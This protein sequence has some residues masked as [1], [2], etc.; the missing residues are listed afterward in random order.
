MYTSR[1][2]GQTTRRR[3]KSSEKL[4]SG[5]KINCAADNAAGLSI[6][7]RMRKQI[8]GL[9]QASENIEDGISLCQVADGALD[10]T[11][12]ILQRMRELTVQAA[13]GTNSE[14]DRQA[15]EREIMQLKDEV[16]RIATT[17][18]F[19]DAIY[20]LNEPATSI[21]SPDPSTP[22]TP[23]GSGGVGSNLIHE[24]STIVTTPAPCTYEGKNYDA[25]DKIIVEGLTTNDT[26]VWFTGGGAYVG[27]NKDP[28]SKIYNDFG[29]LKIADLKTD[30]DGYL[31]YDKSGTAIYAV[32]V[33]DYQ[34]SSGNP[35]PMHF[36][37]YGETC[38]RIAN[39]EKLR[40]MTVDDLGTQQQPTPPP[41][42]PQTETSYKSIIIQAGATPTQADRIPVYLVDATCKGIGIT[43]LTV[44]AEQD[45][46]SAFDMLDNAISQ[47]SSYRSLFGATSNRL[48]HAQKIDDNTAE[49]TQAAESRIRDTDMAAEM[50][51]YSKENILTQVGHA[52]LAQANQSRQGVMSLL[53]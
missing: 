22:T 29:P 19:N 36:E 9:K 7:E 41:D 38:R 18:S 14:S 49:N 31:Y 46:D 15:I 32:Y 13:N 5:Y 47:V 50:V 11:V 25:G 43:D 34:P 20:P 40:F 23:P 53:A 2:L 3:T 27:K 10:E 1:Q 8:R 52:M 51:Q 37:E 39:G 17:T 26:E 44:A 4:S 48:E 45:T 6:S 16:N 28:F 21:Q 12:K 33:T 30:K 35:D 42:T 24:I